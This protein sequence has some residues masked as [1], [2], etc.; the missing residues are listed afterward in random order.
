MPV[1]MMERAAAERLA[2]EVIADMLLAEEYGEAVAALWTPQPGPQTLALESEADELF[3][4]G[5]AGGGKSDLLLGLAFTQHRKSIIFRREYPQLKDLISRSRDIA[6]GAGRFNGQDVTW[7]ELP[8]GRTLE[9]GAVQYLYDWTKY[10]G[11][12]HDLKAF[13]ELPEFLESQ[14]LALIGWARSTL[15]GQRVRIVGTGNPPT[16][17]EGEW[18]IRRWAPWLDPKHPRPARAGELRWYARVD[19]EEIERP[20]GEPFEHQGELIQPRSRTFI[21]ARLSDNAFLRDTGYA[22]VLQNLPEP[23]RSQL[24]Y[25]DF[26]I[27]IDDDPWQVIPTAWIDA[28]MARWTE[29]GR[30]RLETGEPA[31][32]DCVG[33]DVARGG[34]DK[35]ALARRYGRWFAP[36]EKYPGK[37]TP[38]GNEVADLVQRALLDGGQANIDG[39][40]VGASVFDICRLRRMSVTSVIFSEKS[41]AR[42]KSGKLGFINVR[43][44]AYWEFREALDPEGG[45]DLALPPD[46]E[47]KADLCSARWKPVAAGIQIESKEDIVKR[48]GRSPDLG[49]AAVL[50]LFQGPALP[51]GWLRNK[52]G[53]HA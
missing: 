33:V 15:P 22:A 38:D 18:V 14:Y 4:G 43:A 13:D 46:S 32:M 28:A 50:S 9:F 10:K 35:T 11:R 7:R 45:Q 20:D 41:E 26:E 31:P 27:G 39:I 1:R 53:A 16:S 51:F 36:M 12:P 2:A 49:D 52:V 24:L 34:K 42:D 40:G 30:P 25:G 44:Q 8:G 23:L 21:P 17:A 37:S 47:L 48:L 5:S 29:H 19:G 6:A 3:Y